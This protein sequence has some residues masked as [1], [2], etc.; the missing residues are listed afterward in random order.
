MCSD[1]HIDGFDDIH[2]DHSKSSSIA[3]DA[4]PCVCGVQDC[5]VSIHP[6]LA[7]RFSSEICSSRSRWPEMANLHHKPGLSPTRRWLWSHYATYNSLCSRI[8]RQ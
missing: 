8:P 7:D 1:V 4:T 2:I 5:L 6:R 3:V